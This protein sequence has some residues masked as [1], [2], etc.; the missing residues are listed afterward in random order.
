M[1]N[2]KGLSIVLLIPTIIIGVAIFQ[3]FDF[4]NLKFENPALAFV[5]F[6]G[7]ALSIIFQFKNFKKRHEK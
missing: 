3:E 2:K 6:I 1:E 5:Y 4:E 7:F